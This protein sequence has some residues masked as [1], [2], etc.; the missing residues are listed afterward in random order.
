MKIKLIAAACVLALAGPAMAAS[1]SSD[2][3]W[4]DLSPPET[5]F[6]GNWFTSQV[7][8]NDC[9]SFTLSSGASA[10]G[11]TTEIDLS[12]RLDIDVSSVSL[13]RGASLVSSDS[14]ADTFMFGNLGAGSYRLEVAGNVLRDS[15][16]SN[17]L[18]VGYVGQVRTV[19]APVPEPETY[20]MLLAGF[21]G[22]GVGVMRR[23]KA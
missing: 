12:N 2:S 6:F 21:V 19:A 11:W 4:G 5:Q 22:V 17:G 1:C 13:F 20:A 14:S 8:F 23:K 10:S 9:Y 18:G 3:D 7:G 15:G 16:W